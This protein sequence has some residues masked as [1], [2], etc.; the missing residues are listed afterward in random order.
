MPATPGD[1][2]FFRRPTRRRPTVALLLLVVGIPVALL[3]LTRAT[4]T[5]ALATSLVCTEGGA[6]SE[7]LLLENFD[8]DYLVFET[9]RNIVRAGSPARV[10]V[11][12]PAGGDEPNEPSP[13]S[14]GIAEVMARISRLPGME[15]LPIAEIEPISLNAA[16]QIRDFLLREH[17]TTVTVVTPAFRSRRSALVYQSVFEPAGIQVQCVPVF[18]TKRPETWTDTWHGIQDVG[19]QFV[20]LW[21]YRLWVLV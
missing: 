6:R 3:W 15:L 2:F 9:A 1:N 12:V 10:I 18:G 14:Q 16:R 17:L 21:Y 8:P 4:W 20:K 11:P 5:T 13:V 19:L 7:A